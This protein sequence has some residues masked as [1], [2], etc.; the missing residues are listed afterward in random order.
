MYIF[1]KS[2]S[3]QLF[4]SRKV[5]I[6]F[7]TRLIYS[8]R[9]V[10]SFTSAHKKKKYIFFSKQTCPNSSYECNKVFSLGDSIYFSMQITISI[11]FFHVLRFS[12]SIPQ[13]DGGHHICIGSRHSRKVAWINYSGSIKKCSSPDHEIHR[14]DIKTSAIKVKAGK[15]LSVFH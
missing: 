5:S 12:L 2:P 13:I 8:N 9:N 7:W 14:C 3:T 4:L 6:L 1:I 11:L 10:L 15:T